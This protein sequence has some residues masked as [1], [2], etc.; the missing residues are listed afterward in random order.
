MMQVPDAI[1]D[2]GLFDVTLIK[3][4]PK[5]MVIRH[6]SKLYD[7]TLV[8]LPIVETY[9]GKSIRIRS[10]GKIYLEADGESLGHSPFVYEILPRSLKVVVGILNSEMA[11]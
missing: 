9:R 2:D 4:A 3:K 8:K 10:V 7:G 6:A 1:P 11:K 5:W